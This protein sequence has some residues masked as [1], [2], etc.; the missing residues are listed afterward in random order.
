MKLRAATLG[1]VTVLAVLAGGAALVG[2]EREAGGQDASGFRFRTGVALINVTATVTDASGRFV[3]GL[4]Q[5]DFRVY[6]DDV[7]QSITHFSADRVPVSLGIAL[8]TSGSMAGERFGHARQALDRFLFDL[9]DPADELFLVRFSSDVDVEEGW[10]HDRARLSGALR[11]IVPRGG[12]AMYDAI[13]ESVPI[14]DRGTNRKKALLVISDG[15][16]T[17]SETHIGDVKQLI[18]ESEVM[19]YAIGID[20]T[21]Q[22]TQRVDPMPRRPPVGPR[23]PLPFPIPGR[24]QPWP[25]P[26][27]G[28]GGGGGGTWSRTDERVNVAA[29]RSITDDT[30]GRTEIIRSSRDLDPATTGI[31]DELSRQYFLAYPAAASKDGRWHTIRVEVKDPRY[32]VRARRGYIAN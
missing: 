6:E 18:R 1:A 22:M 24:R 26:P 21:P 12:T 23:L 5:E 30:G 2:Q 14:A 15:N 16:D 11:R 10:T 29:L 28:G 32:R 13:A 17:S 4:R 7:P 8:D 31:A 25:N 3:P 20:G 9:L 19:V 27:I